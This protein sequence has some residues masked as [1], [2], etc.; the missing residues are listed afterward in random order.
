MRPKPV[1]LLGR[2]NTFKTIIGDVTFGKDGEWAAPRIVWTQ[3]QDIKG[4]DLKQ[5]EDPATEVV[6]LPSELKSGALIWPYSARR[7]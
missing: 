3:F 4:S 5:F 2:T 1:A 7:H 6:V